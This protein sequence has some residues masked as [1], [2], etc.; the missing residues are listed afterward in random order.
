MSGA[1]DFVHLH[2]HSEFSLLDGLASVDELVKRAA[3]LGQP[4]IALTDHGAMHGIVPFH[5]AAKTAG[6][7]PVIGIEAYITAPGRPMSGRDSE[8]DKDN[9]H[10]LLLAATQ[11][12]Y[13]NLIKIASASQTEGYYYKPRIDFDY[14]AS[15]AE[16]LITTTGCLAA[17]VP[18]LLN[19]EH[20]AADEKKALEWFQRYRELFG[21]ERFYV[22]LQE[23]DI[24]QLRTVNRTLVRWAQ[25][26]D[27]PLVVTNDVHYV[28]VTDYEAHDTLLCVQTGATKTATKR[29]KYANDS[30]YLKS[31]AELE[32]TFRTYLDLPAAAFT[33]TLR[34]AEMCDVDVEDKTF[35]LPDIAIPPGHTYQSFLRF[36]TFEGLNEKYGL[37]ATDP[38]VVDRAEKELGIINQMG[39]DVYFIIVWDLCQAMKGR[40]IWWNVRGSGAGSIVAYATD[41]TLIDPLEHDLIFERFLN[42]GRVSMPDFDL[43]IPDDS[44]EEMIRY[45]AEKYGADH[46]AQIVAF[47]R[48][49][50]RAAVRD[51]GRALDMPLPDVDRIARLIPAIAGK[52]VTIEGCL[53]EGSEF[54]SPE[55]AQLV[56]NDSVVRNLIDATRQLEGVARH[57]STHAAA[58]IVTDKPLTDL[59]PVMRPQKTVVTETVAQFEFPIC[60]SIGL[61]KVDFLGLATLSIMREA[62]RLIQE[63]HGI[64]YT[65]H[66]IPTD[67]PEAFQLLSSG[68]VVGLF[69]VEGA[70]M[71]RILTDMRPSHIKHIMAV[72]SLYRPGPMQYIPNFVARMNGKEEIVYRHPALEP[73]LSETYGIIVYQEQI[74]RVATDLAGY[75]LSEADNMRKAVAKKKEKDLHKHRSK[76]LEG[77]ADG[78]IP[79]D[80]T[81]QIFDDIEKFARYGFPKA[82]GADYALITVQT[83]FLKAQYPL[84]YMAALLLVEREKADKVVTTIVECRRMGIEVLPPDINE[85]GIDFTLAELPVHIKAPEQ[86]P[87]LAYPFPVPPR[88]AIRYGLGAIKNVGEGSVDEILRARADG[89]FTSLEDVCERVDLR[90]INKRTLECLIKAGA[91]DSLEHDR[92]RG[93]AVLDRMMNLSAATW[94]ARAVGQGSLFDLFDF[95]ERNSG[96]HSLF[97]PPPVIEPLSAKDRLNSEKELLGVYVSEHPL[98]RVTARYQNVVTCLCNEVTPEKKDKAVTLAG[99]IA[100][101]RIFFTKKGERMAFVTLEDLQG[102]CDV[103]VFPRL[104]ASTPEQLLQEGAIVLVRGKVDVRNDRATVIA[105]QVTDSIA[106]ATPATGDR[107]PGFADTPPALWTVDE[108]TFGV[109]PEEPPG[110]MEPPDPDEAGDEAPAAPHR[111]QDPTAEREVQPPAPPGANGGAP[112]PASQPFGLEPF[113]TKPAGRVPKAPLS[114]D[115]EPEPDLTPHDIAA[116]GDVRVV[117]APSPRLVRVTFHRGSDRQSDSYRLAQ[118]IS[119]FRRFQGEDRFVVHVDNELELSFPNESTG[120][121]EDLATEIQALLGAGCLQIM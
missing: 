108:A 7:R 60:E 8:Q 59:I 73:I 99:M 52:N 85:S 69:Q 22:E 55:L 42:P 89:P 5:R 109:L 70:G 4:A 46:V 10:L 90:L 106:Y 72:V 107:W 54:Y 53:T 117:Q 26:Y 93:L 74:M 98:E 115:I 86:D 25:D 35:H 77:A 67:Q 100:G 18:S 87:R 56:K 105:D 119:L 97:D 48:M 12:G 17:T 33:N 31:R 16:G 114:S 2:V 65:L 49:K 19:D 38:V 82:H 88:A 30:F 111:P 71:R 44:R 37:R 62:S 34:I 95:S 28:Q 68:E 27:V 29:L 36:L 20:G 43:D 116:P 13:K 6:L 61:L 118:T 9:N 102:K 24:N 58:V 78:G 103:T 47:G 21:P 51:V 1:E 84:E 14:L 75:S 80:I 101:C 79:E 104:L 83:A 15:H 32:T 92:A 94:E 66:N 41:I 113:R 23:H 45:T 112:S 39:F 91:F 64:R 11:I 57:A 121:C 120:Y 40:N 76:M 81:A 50:A 3:E 63:R 96:V 110:F